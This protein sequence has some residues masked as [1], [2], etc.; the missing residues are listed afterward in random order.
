MT[1]TRKTY[2]DENGCHTKRKLLQT[3]TQ[4]LISLYL[5]QLQ[6]AQYVLHLLSYTLQDD[7][8]IHGKSSVKTTCSKACVNYSKLQ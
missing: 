5:I 6:Y 4:N 2:W 8:R 3:E 7:G 1:A